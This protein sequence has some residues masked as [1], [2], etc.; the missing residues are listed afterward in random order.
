MGRG[1]NP[2]SSSEIAGNS[3]VFSGSYDPQADSRY[4]DEYLWVFLDYS[5]LKV[6]KMQKIPF[7]D[8][9]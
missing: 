1:K 6:I 3:V 4:E 9:V 5:S 8:L 7:T 2:A